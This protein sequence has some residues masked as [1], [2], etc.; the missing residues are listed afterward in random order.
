M[1][2]PPEMLIVSESGFIE[3]KFPEKL[4]LKVQILE[5]LKGRRKDIKKIGSVQRRHETQH[6]VTQHNDTQQNDT[7][8][9]TFS[10][11]VHSITTLSIMTLSKMT[12]ALLHSA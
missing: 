2:F 11:M 6:I 4:F 3:S 5:I 7:R 8:I 10:I 12:L 1:F 9:T